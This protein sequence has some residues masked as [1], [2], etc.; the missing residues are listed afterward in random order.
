MKNFLLSLFFFVVIF[1]IFLSVHNKNHNTA[2]KVF[3]DYKKI[4]I[5]IGKNYFHTFVAD[6]KDKRERGLSGIS[7]LKEEEAMIFE[8][9]EAGQYNFWMKDMN[10]PI[11][12]VWID[13]NK[14]IIDIS[15]NITPD[16]YP[17]TFT[18]RAKSKWVLEVGA[19]E[20]KN[21]EIKI[22]DEVVF[23]G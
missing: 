18:S 2:E 11:D 23:G 17:K 14:K 7:E 20:T 21:K 19:N 15:E 8:F 22:G 10:F 13:E 9:S 1:T 3:V 16:T 12:I 4:E 6:T 5:T